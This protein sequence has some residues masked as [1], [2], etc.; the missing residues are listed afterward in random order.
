MAKEPVA[1]A[2]RLDG[3]LSVMLRLHK[4]V[5]QRLLWQYVLSDFTPFQ[6][7]SMR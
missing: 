2:H 6:L 5:N 1:R 7:F 3:V 4:A